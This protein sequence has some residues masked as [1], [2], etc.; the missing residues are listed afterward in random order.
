MSETRPVHTLTIT[1]CEGCA[2]AGEQE[3]SCYPQ[4]FDVKVDCPG[5][6]DSCRAWEECM[7]C[8]ALDLDSDAH[9]ELEQT[10]VA[11]GQEHQT[12]ECGWATRT[13]D[14]ILAVHDELRDI[15]DDS[16]PGDVKPGVYQVRIISDDMPRLEFV[17]V[18]P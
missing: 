2:E 18:T 10:G 5:V 9:E 13:E 14:C 6:V 8:N 7:E 11:H 3:C 16:F 17:E 15:V 4:Q 12:L 1:D